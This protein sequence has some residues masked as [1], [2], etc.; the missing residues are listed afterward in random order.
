MNGFMLGISNGAICLA[1]CA[2]LLIP[3]YLGSGESIKKNFWALTQFL[4]GRFSGYLSFAVVA[5]ATHWLILQQKN[6]LE[7][8]V[9]SAYVFLA[10]LMI[11][12]GFVRVPFCL[13][14]KLK[15]P[16]FLKS[17]LLL[18]PWLLG[19]FTGL[20]LCPPF[21]LAFVGAA[22]TKSLA[23]CIFFFVWFFIGTS[24]YFIAIPFL[25]LLGKI[26]NLRTIGKL[27]AMIVGAYY[28]YLGIIMILGGYQSL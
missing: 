18:F 2:P 14:A 26:E 3:Y 15:W 28:F 22:S 9:G 23:S 19:F 25:G 27:M 12:Y 24:I 7:I 20:N 17:N 4:F 10:G 6:R 21:L 16:A 1:Y 11:Y 8:L 5:W 13:L